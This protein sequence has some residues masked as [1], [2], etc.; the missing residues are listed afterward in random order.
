MLDAASHKKNMGANMHD[1]ENC[2]QTY[3]LSYENN[4]ANKYHTMF[5]FS[6]SCIYTLSELEGN[7]NYLT[8]L[9]IQPY[10]AINRLTFSYSTYFHSRM[11]TLGQLMCLLNKIN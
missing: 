8:T 5:T 10:Q 9:F 4:G 2:W 1:F 7:Y 3:N 6:I 11:K